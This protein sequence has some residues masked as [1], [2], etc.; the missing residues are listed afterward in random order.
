MSRYI[1]PQGVLWFGNVEVDIDQSRKFLTLPQTAIAYNPYGDIVFLI[2]EEKQKK[3]G[4][5]IL[6]VK[7]TFVKVGEKR[8]NQVAIISGIKEGDRVVT[9]GQMK[10][11]NGSKVVINNKVTPNFDANSQPQDEQ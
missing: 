5:S 6:T 4:N 10:L 8:G 9:S 7:Q 2:T 11:K 1:I 3:N